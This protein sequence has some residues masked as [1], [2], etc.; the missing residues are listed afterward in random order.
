V[1]ASVYSSLATTKLD[2]TFHGLS[3]HA[4]ARPNEGKNALLAAA[5]AV[6]NLNAI[7]RHIDGAT[8]INVGTLHAGTGRNVIAD[9]AVMELEI[10]GANTA[11]N[12]YMTDYATR[13]LKAAAD[14]HGCTCDIRLMGAAEALC[15]DKALA[16][17]IEQVCHN[18]QL[19]VIPS[20]PGGGSED[21]SYMMNRVQQ[22][23]GLAAFFRTVCTTASGAH[24]VRYDFDEEALVTGV[25]VF[26]GCVA[27]LLK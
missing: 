23:G 4:G 2:A 9:T 24:T 19:P 22:Q 14:M 21:I 27:D 26:C 16:D 1:V 5:T 13:I 7:P 6:M 11:I 12:D 20:L 10:R 17:R 8:R 15:S 18:L 25:E 3:A